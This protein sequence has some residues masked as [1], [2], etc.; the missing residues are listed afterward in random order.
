[1]E[2]SPVRSEVYVAGLD[3]NV[4]SG[5]NNIDKALNKDDEPPATAL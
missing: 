4:E 5:D 1:M 3:N 2:D